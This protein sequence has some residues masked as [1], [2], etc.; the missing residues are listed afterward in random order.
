F[1]ALELRDEALTL[2]ARCADHQP[3]CKNSNAAYA[4]A[5]L[6]AGRLDEA[7]GRAR[8]AQDLSPGATSEAQFVEHA[9]RGDVA[10]LRA[11]MRARDV[12]LPGLFS[13]FDALVLE[14]AERRARESRVI[15]SAR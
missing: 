6:A 7:L 12:A 2:A 15:G 1:A 8:R 11:A 3:H 9:V 14:V 4:A 13:R 10:A 5:L